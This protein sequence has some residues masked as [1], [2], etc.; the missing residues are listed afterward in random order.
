MAKPELVGYDAFYL[1]ELN[2]LINLKEDYDY[3]R[4][5]QHIG[6]S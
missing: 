6:V 5:R 4:V 3:W 2:E 1:K